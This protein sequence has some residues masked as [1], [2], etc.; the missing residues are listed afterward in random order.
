[1]LCPC[2]MPLHAGPSQ[3]ARITVPG[4]SPLGQRTEYPDAY[5]P[6]LLSG[7]A[8]AAGRADLG[9]SGELPFQGVDLWNAY[10]L[11]WLNEKGKPV[12]AT[13]ELS[14]PATSPQLVES[15]SLK[16]YLNSLNRMRCSSAAELEQRIVRD[17]AAVAGAEPEVRIVPAFDF[18]PAAIDLPDGDCIDDLDVEIATYQVDPELLSLA[19]GADADDPVEETLYSNLLKSNCPIT[20]QPDWATVSLHYRGARIDRSSL[21]AYIVSFHGHDEFHEQ[22]VERIFVDIRRRCA[23]EALSVYARYTRRG[24][25]DINPFRSDFESPPGHR[26]LWRQ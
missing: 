5:A 12:V 3:L 1:M 6:E 9:L 2:R 19:A 11:S 10:E 23:P 20:G 7:F 15:K 13:A 4:E 24:G 26:R 8:R 14:F 21:L 22:C 16:L 18:R 25:L 17:L